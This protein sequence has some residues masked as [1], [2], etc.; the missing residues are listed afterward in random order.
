M[1]ENAMV[2]EQLTDAMIEAGE[3]LTTEL[4]KRG[5]RVAA[6]FWLFVPELNEWR[7]FFASPDVDSRGPRSVYEIVQQV[8]DQLET[9]AAAIPLSVVFLLG[10]DA[11]LVRLLKVAVRTGPS[12][13]RIRFSKNVINGQF[14]EDALIYRVV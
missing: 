4:E 14:I 7:I 10:A 5:L 9:K 8:L 12:V 1:A 3:E 6:A 13:N 11:D 2:K